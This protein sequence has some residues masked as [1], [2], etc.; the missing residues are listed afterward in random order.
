MFWKYNQM[1]AI[2]ILKII[3]SNF[4][5]FKFA[6]LLRTYLTNKFDK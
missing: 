4:Q 5:I 1:I 6:I 3:Y 2:Y